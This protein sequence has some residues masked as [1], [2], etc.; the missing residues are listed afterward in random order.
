MNLLSLIKPALTVLYHGQSLN[1]AETWKNAQ[2]L[3]N[4]GLAVAALVAVFVPSLN[5]PS[6]MI[7]A[8]AVAIASVANWYL[9]L[10]TSK[11]VGI[12]PIELQAKPDDSTPIELVGVAER[13]MPPHSVQDPSAS[14]T[15]VYVERPTAA[16]PPDFF[17]DSF[18]DQ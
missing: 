11:K 14:A 1:K 4:L 3:T 2:A 6:E 7:G 13:R 10:A 15:D 18:G 5:L 17:H 16:L 12:P 9:T 8:V